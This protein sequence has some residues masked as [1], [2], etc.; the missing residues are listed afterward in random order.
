MYL[1]VAFV[2]VC[3]WEFVCVCVCNAGEVN[4]GAALELK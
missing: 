2:C 1:M 4:L 3:V